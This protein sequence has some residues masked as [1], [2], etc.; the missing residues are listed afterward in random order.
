MSIEPANAGRLRAEALPNVG[1]AVAQDESQEPTR[2]IIRLLLPED[3]LVVATLDRADAGNDSGHL[4]KAGDRVGD[5]RAF[6]P[7]RH[8]FAGRAGL[9]QSTI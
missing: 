8:R 5:V 3:P 9:P 1:S 4:A 7:M 2:A 6:V